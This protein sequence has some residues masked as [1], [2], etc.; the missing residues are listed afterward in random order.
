MTDLSALADAVSLTLSTDVT[1]RKGAETFLKGQSV[2]PGFPISLLQLIALNSAPQ[3]VRQAA[4]VYLK[5]YTINIYSDPDWSQTPPDDR[6]AVKSAI[7]NITLTVPVVV[8]RQLSE[9]LAIIAEHEYPNTW[10]QLVPE[11]STKLESTYVEALRQPEDHDATPLIDWARLEGIMETLH[12]IFE[13]YPEETGSNELYTEIIYSL[14]HTQEKVKLLFVLFNRV[15]STSIENKGMELISAIFRNVELLCK[16]FYCLSWQQLP[17]YFEDNLST[18]MTHLRNFLVFES[19][20]I[21]AHSEDEPSPIDKLQTIVLEITNHFAVHYD[22]EFRNFLPQFL[23]DTWALLVRGSNTSKYDSVVTAG[24]RFLTAVS[25]SPDFG[26]F[27][28]PSILNQICKRIVVPNLELREEDEELFEDNP[29]EY[30]RRDLEGSD[31]ETRRRGSVELVKGLCMHFEKPVTEIFNTFIQEMLAPQSDWRKKD[32]VL[33]VITALGWKKGTTAAGA[34]E[35]SDL[36]NVVDFFS[37][38]VMPQLNKCSA[39]PLQLETPI[40]TADL[41]KFVLSFRNQIPKRDAGN[42]IFLCTKLLSAK[43]PVVQTYAAACIERTLTIKD[44]VSVANGNGTAR[45]SA[46]MITVPR[47][48]KADLEPVL[49]DLLPVVV[50]VLR[51]STRAN[52]YVMRLV[53]RFCAVAQDAMGPYVSKLLP[54]LVDILSSVTANPSNPVFNHYLFETLSALIRFNGNSGNVQMFESLLSDHL[55]KVLVDDVTE[56]MPYVFQL[57]SQMM[58]LNAGALPATYKN[59]MGPLL[60]PST[61]EKRGYIPSMVQFL[62]VYVRKNSA[63]VVEANQLQA[64]LGVFQ[65]L[66]ASKATDHYALQLLDSVLE[67]Y[68][69]RTLSQYF[70]SIFKVLMTRLSVAKTA[71]LCSNMLVTLSIFALRFGVST[72]KSSFD[73]LQQNMFVLL[74]RNVWLTEV[75]MIRKP[76]PRRLCAIALTEIACGPD[77]LCANTPY[78][79]L[80]PQIMNINVALTEGIVTDKTKKEEQNDWAEE[81]A[82]HLGA[83]ESYS[84]AHSQLKWGAPSIVVA[85]TLIG[86]RDPRVVL[87]EK[88]RQFMQRHPGKFEP[89][90]Q[91]QVDAQ[92]R[93]AIS[94]YMSLKPT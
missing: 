20:K 4:A 13:R 55:N 14:K 73:Q 87:A 11:L 66:L 12:V 85:S 68:D 15:I 58:A 52:E 43:E 26:L 27:E 3:H 69:I 38:F 75:V 7:V 28:D 49:Q 64:I 1:Q 31:T 36:V 8:R 70:N 62:D 51:D 93:D 56:F 34:T 18:F 61:W 92:A 67:S 33:Y 9:I 30:V 76:D 90:L 88:L 82:S 42:V 32:T 37:E 10:P 80:W 74:L 48:T 86:Q 25:K 57:F 22:E 53:L 45:I 89:L 40:F 41:I 39:N 35:T 21:D 5:N 59:L 54:T 77:S 24:I 60:T 79:E 6:N 16:V 81:E 29:V 46:E 19:P 50:N 94:S 2:R 72:M 78:I 83:G 63:G 47:V 44:K 91:T 17:E 84:A 65:K 23:E 71:K